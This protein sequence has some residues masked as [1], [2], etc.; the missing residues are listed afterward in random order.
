ME[1]HFWLPHADLQVTDLEIGAHFAHLV[2]T[3]LELLNQESFYDKA[4]HLAILRRIQ[5]CFGLHFHILH[6]QMSFHQESNLA[7]LYDSVGLHSRKMMIVL[8]SLRTQ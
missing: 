2:M 5:C 1:L 6:H 7:L 3:V 8:I 4:Y